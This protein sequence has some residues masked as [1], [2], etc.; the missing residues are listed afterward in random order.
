M[1]WVFV[2]DVVKQQD[3]FAI[4]CN[5]SIMMHYKCIEGNSDY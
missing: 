1:V 4:G 2:T 3:D 5:H